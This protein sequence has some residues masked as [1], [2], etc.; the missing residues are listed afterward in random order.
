MI[1]LLIIAD[2]FTGALDTGA[3]FA[4]DGMATYVVEASRFCL[5]A[6]PDETQVL[7]IDA[8]TRHISPEKAYAA[9]RSLAEEGIYAQ[10]PYLYIKVDSTLR[11]NIG[12]YL[13]A[14]IDA[15]GG[16]ARCVLAP[17]LPLLQRTTRN[18]RQYVGEKPLDE[19]EI[20]NDPFTP[21]SSSYLPELLAK[22]TDIESV[23]I[24]A[25]DVR[26]LVVRTPQREIAV[27]DAQTQSDMQQ[28]AA[29]LIA[30][31]EVIQSGSAGL[32]NELARCLNVVKRPY[33]PENETHR[34]FVL[35]GSLNVHSQRQI[36]MARQNGMPCIVMDE[37]QKTSAD[38]VHTARGEAFTEQAA[39]LL[40]EQGILILQT[41]VRDAET[42]TIEAEN[43]NHLTV[44]QNV[45]A[46]STEIIR[47][48]G[49][50][51]AVVFGGDTLFGLL[52][53]LNV[54]GIRPQRELLP[55]VVLSETEYE[56][57]P[58]RIISKAGAFGETDALI[59]IV[60]QLT[61]QVNKQVL[62]H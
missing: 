60:R 23:L 33:V 5:G 39:A 59:R 20:M 31:P 12:A 11:G 19:T 55:G 42:P 34:I 25:D 7:V 53:A 38:Y 37:E 56:G 40:R 48:S 29:A 32:A 6:I 27:V 43:G 62:T 14:A 13:S 16:T 1:E 30:A 47:R 28:I 18:G 24:T 10:I 36:Q 50:D 46:V 15:R 22:Q 49:T 9:V 21:V 17:A 26:N 8:Q 2:D 4:K 51:T 45:G 58:L 41:T 57:A 61:G 44:A 35:S 3:Q 52:D 54:S